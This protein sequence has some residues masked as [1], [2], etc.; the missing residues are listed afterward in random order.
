MCD[1]VLLCF[2][3]CCL[4]RNCCCCCIFVA[5]AKTIISVQSIIDP[6][7]RNVCDPFQNKLFKTI[8]MLQ[9]LSNCVMSLCPNLLGKF[10]KMKPLK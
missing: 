10:P 3:L 5:V 8:L 9:M 2:V 6:K 4:G 7:G 1:F